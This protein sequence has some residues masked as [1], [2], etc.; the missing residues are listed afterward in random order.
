M[1]NRRT[2]PT[3]SLVSHSD[4]LIRSASE[5]APVDKNAVP[6]R[7]ATPA[8]SAAGS[9]V[10]IEQALCQRRVRQSSGKVFNPPPLNATPASTNRL[11][12]SGAALFQ[13]RRSPGASIFEKEP[14]DIT[15]PATELSN[16][17]NGGD[18]P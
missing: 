4:M 10:L 12:I 15:H 17:A 14:S 11:M 16:T 3:N 18:G 9:D 8:P 7:Y 2:P 6:G 5:K 13:P 1:P